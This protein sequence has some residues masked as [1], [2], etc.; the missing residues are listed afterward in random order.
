VSHFF[1]Y[2]ARMKY[3][4]RWGLM[5]N[6]VPENVQEHALQ[7][8]LL[9]H[10]LAVLSNRYFEGRYD[11]AR[12]ALMALFHDAVEI[13]TG[14][15]PTPIKYFSPGLRAAYQEIERHA[16]Q[17]L[18]SQLPEDLRGDYWPL[19]ATEAQSDGERL[20]L[21]AAD[22]LAGYLKC[23]EEE[24]AGNGEFARARRAMERRL[25]ELPVPAVR[26]FLDR[27]GPSFGK[28]LDELS[29]DVRSDGLFDAQSAE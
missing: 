6:V 29:E 19:I 13:F 28:S 16:E 24:R 22:T 27:F 14:D 21:K 8:A 1:A 9:A 3:I 25:N 18:L 7:V 20:L 10:A 17:R 23:V 5:R 15:L 12:I 4:Q 26:M 2:L 11:P